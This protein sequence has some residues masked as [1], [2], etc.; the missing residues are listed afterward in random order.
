MP[1]YLYY[2]AIQVYAFMR[3][4]LMPRGHTPGGPVK[5]HRSILDAIGNTP[6]I[7]LNSLSDATGCEVRPLNRPP[8]AAY[9]RSDIELLYR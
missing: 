9:T 6:L 4:R 8:P 2:F 7:R 3:P 5:V 1:V